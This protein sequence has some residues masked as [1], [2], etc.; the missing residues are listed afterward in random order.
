MLEPERAMLIVCPSCS[1]A[2]EVGSAALG[3][4]GRSVRC[5]KCRTVWVARAEDGA[6]MPAVAGAMD[7]EI[8]PRAEPAP[9][10]PVPMGDEAPG[11]FLV[12]AVIAADGAENGS[13]EA[14]VMVEAPPLVPGADPTRPPAAGFDPGVPDS[15]ESIAAR[16]A[17]P[18]RDRDASR[19]A[20]RRFASLPVVILALVAVLTA[21]VHWRGSVVRHLPQTASLFAAVGLPVNLR[22]L[23]FENVKSTGEFH[24][25]MMVLVVE[26]TIVNMTR[27][28]LDVPR[29]RFAVRNGSGHEVYAWTALPGRT[30]LVSGETLPFR[31]RLASPPPDGRDVIVRFF[32]RRDVV[33]GAK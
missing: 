2:Y 10:P 28:T 30:L 18:T 17:P 24:D 9:R 3:A 14:V 21:L 8:L 16:R 23:V 11:H 7:G 4:G 20:W 15:I 26:G 1:T 32:N 33:A 5:A 31:T 19:P 22:G 25:G 12:D 13:G 27:T 29:L 6:P